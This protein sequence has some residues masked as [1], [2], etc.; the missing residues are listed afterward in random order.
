VAGR[1]FGSRSGIGG[2][3]PQSTAGRI[4][5]HPGGVR[6]CDVYSF[7]Y[8]P[9]PID[10]HNCVTICMTAD[11]LIRKLKRFDDVMVIPS[12]GTGISASGAPAGCA[13]RRASA[14]IGRASHCRP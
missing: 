13:H 14:T 7:A 5:P 10:T 2:V 6:M 11:E 8:L 4:K 9:L 3:P 1:R 12:R